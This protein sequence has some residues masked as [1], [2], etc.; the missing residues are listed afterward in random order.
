MFLLKKIP[1]IT[2]STGLLKGNKMR[3][4]NEVIDEVC[5][6]PNIPK[7]LKDDLMNIKD[8][9]LPYCPPESIGMWWK[10]AHIAIAPHMPTDPS[11]LNEWQKAFLKIWTG[12]DW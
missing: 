5:K 12:K 10:N 8:K 4:L 11:N 9:H 3:K 1:K 2:T 6:V 7:I